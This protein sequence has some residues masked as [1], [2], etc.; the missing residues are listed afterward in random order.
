MEPAELSVVGYLKMRQNQREIDLRAATLSPLDMTLSMQSA[1]LLTAIL[2]SVSESLQVE[3]EAG[4]GGEQLPLSKDK[5]TRIE[6]LAHDLDETVGSSRSV[7][8]GKLDFGRKVAASTP[9]QPTASSIFDAFEVPSQARA[10]QNQAAASL[11]FDS[12]DVPAQACPPAPR[13]EVKAS[14]IFDSFDAPSS[15][16]GSNQQPA[17][18]SSIDTSVGNGCCCCCC[19]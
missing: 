5:K 4:F 7:D 12:F 1:A 3:S 19:C 6:R 2:A 10:T 16:S 18:S 9:A 13:N 11:I 14:S 15:V 8:R 17:L